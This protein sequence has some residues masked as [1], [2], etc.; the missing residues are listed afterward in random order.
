MFDRKDAKLIKETAL[1]AAG[2]SA[3]SEIIDAWAAVRNAEIALEIPALANLANGK[4]ATVK[5]QESAD[6]STFADAPWAASLSLTGATSGGSAQSELRIGIPSTAKRFLKAVAS[7]EADGGN[8]T[9]A[10]FVFALAF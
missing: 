9:A 1:P 4:K 10:K 2:A 3:S 5:I 6:G 7:V 8:N